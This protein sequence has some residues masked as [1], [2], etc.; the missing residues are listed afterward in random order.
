MGI[1][2][3]W[4]GPAIECMHMRAI[5]SESD[6]RSHPDYNAGWDLFGSAHMP[7]DDQQAMLLSPEED[8]P[9]WYN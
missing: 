4:M 6:Y 8:D 2:H 5:D 1:N 3:T 7:L 9:R